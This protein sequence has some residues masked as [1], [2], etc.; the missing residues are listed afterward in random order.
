VRSLIGM[1]HDLGLRVVAEG[2][3]RQE[4]LDFLRAMDCDL[5]QGFLLSRPQPA[6]AIPALL[7]RSRDLSV[8]V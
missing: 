7:H 6:T 5:M 8:D 4:Q 3:E 1:A 2:V